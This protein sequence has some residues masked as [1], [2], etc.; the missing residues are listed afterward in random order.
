M[1]ISIFVS[2]L[3]SI[4]NFENDYQFNFTSFVYIFQIK[5]K[6]ALM[7]NTKFLKQVFVN[8]KYIKFHK[9]FIVRLQKFI[10]FKL[11][12]NKLVLNIIHII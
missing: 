9:F 1:H 7:I 2:N 4:A 10:K 11:T 6:I 5:I 12:D 3:K 8:R